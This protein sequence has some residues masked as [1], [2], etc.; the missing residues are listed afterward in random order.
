MPRIICCH[1]PNTVL[2][3][4]VWEWK[5]GCRKHSVS[6]NT[7]GKH[8][9][10]RNGEECQCLAWKSFVIGVLQASAAGVEWKRH[11]TNTMTTFTCFKIKLTVTRSGEGDGVAVAKSLCDDIMCSERHYVVA[12]LSDFPSSARRSFRVARRSSRQR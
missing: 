5:L 9:Q 2:H 3:F 6:S 12:G 7:C 8:R 1:W 4:A 10:G 11:C